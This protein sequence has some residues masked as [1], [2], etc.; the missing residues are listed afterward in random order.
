M[1]PAELM[2][3]DWVYVTDAC[4]NKNVFCRITRIDTTAWV[5]VDG[6]LDSVGMYE[7]CI[8]PIPLTPDIL[9]KNGFKSYNNSSYQLRGVGVYISWRNVGRLNISFGCAP[10]TNAHIS[11]KYVHELQHALRLCGIKKEVKL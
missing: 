2:I 3:G 11:V 5:G 9:V 8:F 6:E 1:K 4:T 7:N 10:I